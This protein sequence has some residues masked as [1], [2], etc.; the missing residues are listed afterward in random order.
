VSPWLHVVGLGD[1]G[2]AGMA[3]AARTLVE[4]ADLLVGGE[5]H[6]ALV[7]RAG[8]E[9]L[10]WESPLSRTV[11]RIAER[12]GRPVVVLGSGDPL[13][14][15]IG[16]TLARRFPPGEIRVLPH[17]GAFSLAAAR[18]LWPLAECETLTL[19]GRPAERVLLHVAPGAR[20]L[21]LSADGTTPARV[22]ELLARS[23]WGPS[24][25]TVLEHLDGVQ[26]RRRQALAQ[27][28]DDERC[29]DLNTIA[30]QCRA[31]PGARILPR[32]PGLPDE[33]FEHDGQLTKREIRAATLA[34]LAPLPGEV[35]WDVGA[36][37][38][39]VAIEWL[40]AARGTRAH[41]VERSRERCRIIAVNAA[42]LGVPEL[43]IVEG[44]APAPLGGLPPPDA[45][46]IGGGVSEPGVLDAAWDAL[47]PGGRLVANAVTLEGEAALVG[48][49]ARIGGTLTRIA[50]SR[51]AAIGGRTGWRPLMPVTQYA[52][53]KPCG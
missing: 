45:V 49:Y 16:V 30:V 26:E 53:V 5:R 42:E 35:L 41:A 1:D 28:W 23:G 43:A 13:W 27:D 15:G 52:A 32:T 24:A 10:A 14:Y 22:A 37:C 33:A 39:S 17:V 40:R 4:R 21:I 19:H 38:G 9:R 47:R 3:A 8:A 18:M 51:A 2:L 20:L 44:T 29:A 50:V 36:G 31:A 11:E 34:A 48:R 7:E 46:F 12:R 25:M 6:L